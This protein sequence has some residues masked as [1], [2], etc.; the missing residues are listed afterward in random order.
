MLYLLK[1]I[2]MIFILVVPYE[3]IFLLSA[4][5]LEPFLLIQSDMIVIDGHDIEF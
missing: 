2:T 5:I 3:G 1:L 4:E